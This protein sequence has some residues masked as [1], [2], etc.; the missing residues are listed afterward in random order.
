MISQCKFEGCFSNSGIPSS[1]STFYKNRDGYKLSPRARS[2]RL[3]E[4]AA[5]REDVVIEDD[6]RDEQVDHVCA[7]AAF[8]AKRVTISAEDVFSRGGSAW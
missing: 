7:T 3:N 2:E 1:R 8:K 5:T 4:D 6:Q